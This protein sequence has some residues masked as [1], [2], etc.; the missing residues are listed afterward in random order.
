MTLTDLYEFLL[1]GGSI[2]CFTPQQRNAVAKFILNE[3]SF[4]IGPGTL[5]YMS[6]TPDGEDYALVKLFNLKSG[7]VVSFCTNSVGPV[8]TFSHI[9]HLLSLDSR[10][11][12]RTDQEFSDAFA[13]LMN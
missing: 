4:P 11:D 3:L 5:D 1:R 6:R 12:T 10:I 9:S 8:V 2:K 13:E 7:K